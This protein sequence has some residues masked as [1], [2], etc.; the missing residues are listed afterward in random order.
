MLRLVAR[1]CLARRTCFTSVLGDV[2]HRDR[3][4]AQRDTRPLPGPASS[5]AA[6]PRRAPLLREEAVLARP[7][8]RG[9]VS[10]VEGRV[11][12]PQGHAVRE[13]RWSR[14][15]PQHALC[16]RQALYTEDALTLARRRPQPTQSIA[17]VFC[18][19]CRPRGQQRAPYPELYSSPL[20]R[21]ADVPAVVRPER[22]GAGPGSY[23]N[24]IQ[25]QS[26]NAIAVH[27]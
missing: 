9:P 14:S 4:T 19:G 11:R 26:E 5:P 27:L 17:P 12:P 22:C 2:R 18:P 10:D 3:H 13:R 21:S 16:R 8:L 6:S 15:L 24:L 23:K 7:M 1:R 20:T 25:P